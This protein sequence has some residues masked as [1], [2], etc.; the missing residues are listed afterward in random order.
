MSN[1]QITASKKTKNTPLANLNDVVDT[2]S[3]FGNIIYRSPVKTEGSRVEVSPLRFA[4][5][6]VQ[7]ASPGYWALSYGGDT[8]FDVETMSRLMAKDQRFKTVGK[9]LVDA[10]SIQAIL[11]KLFPSKAKIWS[12]EKMI[13]SGELTQACRDVLSG[14]TD[15]VTT[16]NIVGVILLNMISMLGIVQVEK[17]YIEL[18][19]RHKLFPSKEDIRTEILRSEI[20]AAMLSMSTTITLKDSKFYR[21]V[22]FQS[23]AE[24]ANEMGRAFMQVGT[25]TKYFDGVLGCVRN[26]LL[27]H[28]LPE[29]DRLSPAL[30]QSAILQEMSRNVTIASMALAS[31]NTEQAQAIPDWQAV[32]VVEAIYRAIKLS[33]RFTIKSLSELTMSMGHTRMVGHQNEILGVIAYHNMVSSASCQ[34]ASLHESSY[35]R[36]YHIAPLTN[37]QNTLNSAISKVFPPDHTKR[38]VSSIHSL[39][40]FNQFEDSVDRTLSFIG[41]GMSEADVFHYACA[42]EGVSPYLVSMEDK[43]GDVIYRIE[44]MVDLTGLH[45]NVEDSTLFDKLVTMDPFLALLA[46]DDK[47]PVGA[48]ELGHSAIPATMVD[49]FLM[50]NPTSPIVTDGLSFEWAIPAD[51]EL[52]ASIEVAGSTMTVAMT[53]ADLMGWPE[54][55]DVYIITH[56]LHHAMMGTALNMYMTMYEQSPVVKDTSASTAHERDAF[57]KQI[58]D[59]IGEL[60]ERVA[61]SQEGSRMASQLLGRVRLQNPGDA[62]ATKLRKFRREGVFLSQLEFYIGALALTTAGIMSFQQVSD[63][64]QILRK[65]KYFERQ[66]GSIKYKVR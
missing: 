59:R 8:S 29:D 60:I 66:A 63:I 14:R 65:S 38:V 58:A 6:I 57:R 45:L 36:G 12:N 49:M 32:S 34:V 30:M 4:D 10:S 23:V 1:A 35:A 61:Q 7:S 24:L 52:T 20:E 33:K 48:T 42:T 37:H 5:G 11:N 55:D 41:Y 31:N 19:Y 26:Y 54:F 39:L 64:R 51:K 25:V 50:T 13:T 62:I 56:P 22:L 9:I 21:P 3:S 43:A 16:Q 27:D 46:V 17:G 15:D 2:K 53:F 18:T 40:D 44:F 28:T 47:E